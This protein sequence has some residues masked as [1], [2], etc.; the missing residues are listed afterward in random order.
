M[1][2]AERSTA[3]QHR[4]CQSQGLS[5]AVLKSEFI[6]AQ[7]RYLTI[8]VRPKSVN[9]VAVAAPYRSRPGDLP[10]RA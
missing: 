6:T 2:S 5:L 10:Q 9:R 8:L 4:V 1:Q 3:P 7:Q